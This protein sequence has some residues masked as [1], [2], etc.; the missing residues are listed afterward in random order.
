MKTSHINHVV[1]YAKNFYRH[2]GDIIKD[3][4]RFMQMDGHSYDS[5]NT[6]EKVWKVMRKDYLEWVNSLADI[7]NYED[8]YQVLLKDADDVVYWADGVE[9]H[10]WHIL[11]IYSSSYIP[12]SSKYLGYPKYDQY[13]MPQFSLTKPI[14]NKS[15]S[16]EEMI[17]A[18]KKVLDQTHEDRYDEYMNI[19]M[20]KYPF[21]KVTEV[22]TS[23]GDPVTKEGLESELWDEYTKFMDENVLE[24]G[25]MVSGYFTRYTKHFHISFNTENYMVDVQVEA[26]FNTITVELP[27][28]FNDK[29]IHDLL[30][31]A[32]SNSEFIERRIEIT[33]VIN[34]V[35]EGS[36]SLKVINDEYNE[37]GHIVNSIED[38]ESSFEN[39]YIKERLLEKKESGISTGYFNFLVKINDNSTTLTINFEDIFECSI[40]EH[41]LRNFVSSFISGKKY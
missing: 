22:F 8:N 38:I 34:K 40:M 18:A 32:S 10:I 28:E 25:E 11:I 26:I 29:T 12:M 36:D 27:G 3:M 23:V 33:K 30:Q 35:F 4:Q 16:Y 14:F 7:P 24:D 41:E 6:P 19:L 21:E 15:Q 39:K 31:I 2:T 37:Y 5:I 17:T 9:A 1:L 13:H 20:D